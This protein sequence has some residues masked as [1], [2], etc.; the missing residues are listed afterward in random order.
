MEETEKKSLEP[1]PPKHEKVL[2]YFLIFLAGFHILACPYTKVEESFNL[3]ACHDILY[4]GSDIEK[5]D[6][7]EFPGVVPRTF[8]GPLVVSSVAFP[9]VSIIQILG[10]SKLYSQYIVRSV[11]GSLV[12]WGFFSY[13]S[14]VKE[15]L[16]GQLHVWLTLLTASQFHFL[17]YSSRPLPNIFALVLVLHALA[18]WLKGES[19][20]FIVLSAGAILI[21][22]GELAI[23]LGAILLMELLVGRIHIT[24]VIFVGASS[25]LAWIPLTVIVD[26]WFWQR[27]LWPEMEVLYYNIVL[28]KSS[29]WGV[30]PFLWYFYSA[31]PRALSSSLLLLPLAPFV[32]Q[33]TSILLFPSFVFIFLYSFLPHKELRFIIYCL[34]VLNTA[35]GAVCYRIWINF[36]KSILNKLLVLG[37]IFHLI[38]NF[39]CSAGLIYVSRQNYPGGEAMHALHLLEEPNSPVNVHLDVFA[40]QTGVSRFSQLN[41]GWNYDKSENATNEELSS[42]SHILLS[43]QH[44]YTLQFKPFLES[45]EF[46]AEIEAFSQIKLDYSQFPAEF[47]ISVETK[48]AIFILRR[49]N[50][51]P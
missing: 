19:T 44:K 42:F 50:W 7:H 40:C 21:F 4:H 38:I 5:Y 47:P 22:R 26:S 17:F 27:T 6:H 2:D 15:R 36:H 29:D 16:G 35:A 8:L 43:G 13:R 41:S 31:L 12:L 20:R 23:F 9:F 3:Q 37:V 24:H 10:L 30:M 51:Q 11:L 49:K 1:P 39:C 34:P 18:S 32:D 14:A 45:H 48:P 33:R 46:L 25:L 28:N